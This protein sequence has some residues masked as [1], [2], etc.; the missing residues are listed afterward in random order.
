MVE[1]VTNSD[2]RGNLATALAHLNRLLTVDAALAEAQA[3]EIL[4]AVPDQPQAAFM[5]AAAL[6]A[7][8]KHAEAIAALR[9]VVAS[10]PNHISAWRALGDQHT[11]A[12]DAAAAD[13]AYM[14]H[15]E[16]SVGDPR[17]VVAATAL[18]E[19]SLSTAE[20]ALR[21][22]LK[23]HPTDIGA[24]RMLAE[25]AS[26]LRR[27]E[28]AEKLLLRALQLAPS[29][30]AARSNYASMLHRQNKS[31]EALAQVEI[32][33]KRDPHH[34]GHRNLEAAVLARLGET[35]RAI[36][37]YQGVL[38]D[39]PNQPKVWMSL[40][41]TLKTAGRQREAIEAYRESLKL[42]P[43]LGETW[44][45]LANLKTFRFTPD[46]IA[47]MD[48]EAARS[49]ISDEDRWHLHFA[50]GKALEDH[51]EF[52]A[53]FAHY[54]KGNAL[55]RAVLD[56]Q[57]D[58]VTAHKQLM[59]SVLTAAF[60]R[61]RAEGGC[62][63]PDPIFIVGLPRAG[64]TLVEQ[65]LSSHSAVEG[66]MELP[67]IAAIAGRLHEEA[68]KPFYPDVIAA[69]TPAE[70]TRLG[71]EYLERTRIHRKLG[72]PFFIDKMPN[73]FLQIG[74]I[75]LILPKAKIIDMRRHP[76]ACGFS[77]FKQ[78]FARGQGFTYS[79]T[80]IGRYYA[81][82]VDLMAHYDAVLPGRIHRLQYESLVQDLEGNVRC[83]LE[84]CGLPFEENCLRFYQNDRIVRT[85]SSEQVRLP[86]FSEAVE[87]WRNYETWLDPL[88]NALGTAL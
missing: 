24:M 16:A 57:A 21:D 1:A 31:T 59:Q 66:T 83:L 49:D 30:D 34:P 67:D 45:S 72:R 11:L 35:T 20:Q 48:R 15:V 88:R 7:Q 53:S 87:H 70:R 22:F 86:I 84:Y 23:N 27:Y 6:R 40:G 8:G 75:A 62:E 44:W 52:A 81:D 13:A 46:D 85:A 4:K 79:L 12:G 25:A 19:N 26:R 38:K 51:E 82:Y 71:E 76:M 55:R 17:L 60:F 78:H 77:C 5:L 73:N 10:D 2:P 56:Y 33:L 58:D 74:F 32:L 18:R 37:A 28:D 69:L 36:K 41:H 80:D 63:A 61:Q 54:E 29:F 3:R 9:K 47:A 68:G 14:R 42:S 64:S 43:S 50:L 65:I 39:I